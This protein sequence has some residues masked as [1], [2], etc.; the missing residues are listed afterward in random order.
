MFS[1]KYGQFHFNK[2]MNGDH[3]WITRFLSGTVLATLDP[4]AMMGGSLNW[5]VRLHNGRTGSGNQVLGAWNPLFYNSIYL[6]W[7]DRSVLT[8]K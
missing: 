4:M 3:R 2:V 5:G 6:K 8:R 1:I 7:F